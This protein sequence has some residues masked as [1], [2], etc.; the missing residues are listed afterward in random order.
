M[1]LMDTVIFIIRHAEKPEDKGNPH[2]APEGWNR[3]WK[4]ASNPELLGPPIFCVC[5][6]FGEQQAG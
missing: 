6:I 1:L 5:G 4:L 3:A 2:L